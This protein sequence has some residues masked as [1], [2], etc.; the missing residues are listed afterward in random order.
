MI[1][2]TDKPWN[3]ATTFYIAR[4]LEEISAA[5]PSK[6][7]KVLDLGCGDGIV[8]DQLFDY[9][10]D[11]YGYDLTERK[12][13]LAQKLGARF[14]DKLDDH[15]RIA[16]DERTIP[17]ES[18]TFDAIYANQ[19]FEHVKFIDQIYAECAR[20]LKPGGVMITLFP[21]ATYPIELHARIPFAHWLPPG[22]LRI[23]YLQCFY[24]LHLRPRWQNLSAYETAVHWDNTLKTICFYRFLNEIQSL[25]EHYFG[26]WEL[27]THG[28]I[29]AKIEL[30]NIDPS[31]FRRKFGAF[32]D[33]CHGPVL[34]YLITHLFGAVFVLKNPKAL[35]HSSAG[36]H[37]R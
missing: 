22:Q 28:Y 25:S 37:T 6:P 31:S 24:A 18:A 14:G 2:A 9:G 11:L 8:M 3:S 4:K 30:L 36:L 20:V 7:L 10:H 26:S 12:E 27:D 15:I 16:P 19:V 1:A 21:L 5:L 32:M 13:V 23:A 33:A 17:F 29:R 35:P 34:D